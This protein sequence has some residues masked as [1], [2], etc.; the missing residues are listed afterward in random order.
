MQTS[1]LF[2]AKNVTVKSR[3]NSYYFYESVREGEKVFSRYLG[4][5]QAQ[6]QTWLARLEVVEAKQEQRRRDDQLQ[7]SLDHYYI[8]V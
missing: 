7:T 1:P 3:G 8:A 4:C 5:G 2:S 6:R